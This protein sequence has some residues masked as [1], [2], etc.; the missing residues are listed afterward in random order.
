MTTNLERQIKR[1]YESQDLSPEAIKRLRAMIA[2]GPPTSRRRTLRWLAAAGLVIVAVSLAVIVFVNRSTAAEQIAREAAIEHNRRLGVE[3]AASDY[4]ALRVKMERLDF[5]PVEPSSFAAMPM[6]LLGGRYVSLTGQPAVQL[7][8]V[9]MH[10][11]RCTLIEA[12]LSDPL[13][14]VRGTSHFQVDGLRIDVW[15]ENGLVMVLARPA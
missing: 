7:E 12:R 3:V 6:R 15:N 13:K 14:S 8:L 9:D 11:E 10:G 1:Y 5:T 2:A 4:A